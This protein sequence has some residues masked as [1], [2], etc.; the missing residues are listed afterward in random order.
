MD[1]TIALQPQYAPERIVA[2]QARRRS[3]A[4]PS[5]DP[6]RHGPRYALLAVHDPARSPAWRWGRGLRHVIDDL[7]FSPNR[8]DEA[9]GR[10]V[11]FR[12][13]LVRCR[14]RRQ[15]SG[16]RRRDPALFAAHELFTATSRMRTEVEARLLAGQN[17]GE[18]AVITGLLQEVI[19][20]Y[21]ATFFNVGDRLEARD[22][23]M[24]VAIGVGPSE[25]M[26]TA[27]FSRF[28][29][30]AAY[31]GGPAV[32]NALLSTI[33]ADDG[34]LTLAKLTDWSTPEG[35]L[36]ARLAL[37]VV[38]EFAHLSPALVTELH[39]IRDLIDRFERRSGTL[40]LDY[41]PSEHVALSLT[42]TSAHSATRSVPSSEDLADDP[43]EADG[44]G[45]TVI[46]A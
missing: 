46:A 30:T 25:A 13:A 11:R 9:T 41:I 7:R 18:I 42:A 21:E 28:I 39:R 36:A 24:A 22:W 27:T 43:R 12:R 38:T 23:I 2:G 14:T 6:R 10:A 3:T 20:L 5:G 29:K 32:L 40:A 19:E 4:N 45:T 15:W 35:Q 31:C 37:S 33:V 8:D 26:T 16:L 34:S 17:A 44:N 1:S